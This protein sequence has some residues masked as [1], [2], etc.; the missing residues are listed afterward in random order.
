MFRRVVL[1]SLAVVGLAG[2]R[3]PD[4]AAIGPEA[5]AQRAAWTDPALVAAELASSGTESAPAEDRLL[6]VVID[7]PLA[8]H[9]TTHAA[10]ADG[11]AGF[12]SSSGVRQ[13]TVSDRT[14]GD[15][16]AAVRR[17]LAG[18]ERARGAF[19]ADAAPAWP[20]RGRLRITLV[21]S[22]GRLSRDEAQDALFDGTSPLAPLTKD[23]LDLMQALMHLR[24]ASVK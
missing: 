7:E 5:D 13:R 16:R 24:R 14:A 19:T 12:F 9:V 20:R 22:R 2:C 21:T 23:Y 11:T 3:R 18:A 4:G 1:C 17:L 10:F 8:E 15:V 6:A